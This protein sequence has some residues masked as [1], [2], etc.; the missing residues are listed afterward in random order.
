MAAALR[1]WEADDLRV[2]HYYLIICRKDFRS[3]EHDYLY[4]LFNDQQTIRGHTQPVAS[5]AFSPDGKKIVSGS[6]DKTVKVWDA[7]SGQEIL[8]FKGHTATVMCVAFSPDSKKIVSISKEL[9]VWDASNGQEVLTIK[10][11]TV[12]SNTARVT[13][14][15]FKSVAFSPDGKKFVSGSKESK[16]TAEKELGPDRT[17]SVNVS[18]PKNTLKVWDASRSMEPPPPPLS[19]SLVRKFEGHTSAVKCVALSPSFNGEGGKLVLTG[20]EDTTAVLWEAATGNKLQT[21]AGHDLIVTSVALSGDGKHVLTG[22]GDTTAILWEAASGKKIQ[23]CKGHAFKIDGVA[24]SGDGKLVLTGAI[25]FYPDQA[26]ILWEAAGG[27]RIQTFQGHKY[28]ESTEKRDV[29]GL[30]VRTI[31]GQPARIRCVAL[32]ANGKLALTGSDDRTAI[33]WDATSGKTIQTF[34]GHTDEVASVALSGDGKFVLT[35]SADMS[36]IL[37]E[38]KPAPPP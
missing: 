4:T 2:Y 35:G 17:E 13:T 37:W 34:R 28:L 25:T 3:W 27:K 9:K 29:K 31:Q 33:L 10:A 21:Y 8:T 24:L 38:I 14:L 32:S 19:D 36:A 1:A 22:S 23:T 6:G 16:E 11:P 30:K 12:T 7:L 15:Y 26:T 18:S 5:V 20:S